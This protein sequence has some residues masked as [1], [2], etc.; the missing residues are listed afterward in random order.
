M[1]IRAIA[2]AAARRQFQ[3]TAAFWIVVQWTL[4]RWHIGA[5]THAACTISTCRWLVIVISLRRTR[6]IVIDTFFL[7]RPIICRRS[8]GCIESRWRWWLKATITC[9]A[10]AINFAV[11]IIFCGRCWCRPLYGPFRLFNPKT[12]RTQFFFRLVVLNILNCRRSAACLPSNEPT[13]KQK[14]QR[15]REREQQI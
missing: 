10:L 15:E 6:R 3:I 11:S 5:A 9:S 12:R 14:V 13:V 8:D 1:V 4:E 7:W 2:A